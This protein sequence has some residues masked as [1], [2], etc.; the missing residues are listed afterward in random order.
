V[1]E[2]GRKLTLYLRESDR[3]GEGLVSDQLFDLFQ[4]AGLR[5]SVLLRGVEGFGR[6]SLVES[7]RLETLADDLPLVAV[8]VDEVG[9]ID[10]VLPDVRRLMTGGLVTVERAR[11]VTT[12]EVPAQPD[13]DLGAKL[14]VY[15]GRSERSAGRPAA[16][17]LIDHVRAH[18]ADAGSVLLGLDGTVHGV[19]RRA[20]FLSGNADVPVMVVA[21]GSHGVV[22]EALPGVMSMLDDPVVTLE[23]VAI[24]DAP[25]PTAGE[26]GWRQKLMVH[27][28]AEA[29]SAGRPLHLAALAAVRAHG[30]AGATSLRGTWGFAAGSPAHGD[31][32]RRLRR[33]T[34]VL[35]VAVDRAESIA[36]AWPH[37]RS[38]VAGQGIVTR[39][40]VPVVERIGGGPG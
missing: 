35:T 16:R 27:C 33:R 17:A 21:V 15:C 18:G 30:L 25:A 12:A 1:T 4:R 31:S 38:L 34:P 14:T 2:E 8:A 28:G 39:E 19:R 32:A 29:S 23:R 22:C 37:L 5:V 24:A 10:Q 26:P 7:E 20:R 9:R 40:W 36:E 11:L 3:V 13:L 6:S